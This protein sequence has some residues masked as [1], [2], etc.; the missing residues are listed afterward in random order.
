MN[1][2]TI[3][4]LILALSIGV[5]LIIILL[6]TLR[7]DE[8]KEQKKEEQEIANVEKTQKIVTDEDRIETYDF[9]IVAN[10]IK[11]YLSG[12]NQNSSRFYGRDEN[13]NYTIV[14]S[15]EEINKSVY[16]LLSSE[17]IEKN[18]ITIE[19]VYEY[20]P[21]LTQDVMFVPIDMKLKK[22]ENV[23]KY[24]IYGYTVDFEYNFME[25]IYV[26]VNLDIDNKTYSVEPID[27]NEYEKGNIQN[28][29]IKVE[30]NDNNKFPYQQLSEEYRIK[31]YF[32]NY[33]TM[34][35]SN[36][37]KAY[38]FLNKEYKE[39]SFGNIDNFKK[40]IKD[41]KETIK[42]ATLSEY[43]AKIEEEY[44]QYIEKDEKENY[45]IFNISD[46]N[47]TQFDVMLDIYIIG[48]LEVQENYKKAEEREKV[49]IN[50]M[51]FISGIND[52]NYYYT[53]NILAD[54]FKNNQFQKQED[55]E[56]YVKENFFEKNTVKDSEFKQEGKNYIYDLTITDE[57]GNT[58]KLTII[59][60][61]QEGTDFIMSFSIE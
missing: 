49:T 53:Y 9:L 11:S 7:S 43:H 8:E 14:V 36:E 16:N 61:L 59:M 10:C 41:K 38:Q 52:K 39:K 3:Q 1:K 30:Q 22:G 17:Y 57:E 55:F 44:T 35:L 29:N 24:M 4:K 5:I 12:I 2:K 34:L 58:K 32:R 20:V 27:K 25:D 46:T 56:Q 45:Y 51:K 40:Y 15:Q 21:K 31:E 6:L 19:N 28:N 23:N 54:T 47:P 50:T 26:I 48:S 60:Q 42:I 13:N 33:K 37:E 18:N